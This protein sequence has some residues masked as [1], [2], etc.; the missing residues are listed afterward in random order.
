MDDYIPPI[1][2]LPLYIVLFPTILVLGALAWLLLPPKYSK[3]WFG[4]GAGN[5]ADGRWG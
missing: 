4:I 1:I 2:Q 5:D 3:K